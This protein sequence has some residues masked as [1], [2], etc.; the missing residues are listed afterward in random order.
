M[1]EKLPLKFLQRS[2]VLKSKEEVNM[3]DI[4]RWIT[5]LEDK[6]DSTDIDIKVGDVLDFPD[7]ILLDAGPCGG[8]VLEFFGRKNVPNEGMVFEA[9]N[10]IYVISMAMFRKFIKDG[11]VELQPKGY[12]VLYKGNKGTTVENVRQCIFQVDR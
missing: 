6:K 10:H 8:A 5:L 7:D 9:S 12:Q 1:T 3:N 4:R 2:G 11:A